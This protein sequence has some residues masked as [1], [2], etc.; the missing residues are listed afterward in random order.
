M[1]LRKTVRR[2]LLAAV[3]VVA[4]SSRA[5]AWPIVLVDV[6]DL[7]GGVWNYALTIDNT[8]GPEPIM[9]LNVLHGDTVFGLN[10]LSNIVAPA[11]WDFFPPDEFVDDLFFFSLDPGDDVGVGDTLDG[12]SFDSLT[13]PGD[14]TFGDFDVDLV[15][16]ETFQ[17]LPIGDIYLPEPSSLLLFGSG[18]AAMA[19]RVRKRRAA[20]DAG[21]RA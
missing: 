5:E 14:L 16:G 3:A 15:G 20:R 18:V 11:G 1:T 4:L 6:T 8:T 7:G 13:D 12:F 21:P 9:G 10:E 17:Q 19:A 2:W